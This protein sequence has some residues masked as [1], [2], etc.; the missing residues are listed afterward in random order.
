MEF[1]NTNHCHGKNYFQVDGIITVAL[2]F[3]NLLFHNASEV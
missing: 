3:T 1:D 2:P